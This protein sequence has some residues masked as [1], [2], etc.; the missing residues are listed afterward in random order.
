MAASKWT[1]YLGDQNN[2]RVVVI[3]AVALVQE[4]M[5]RHQLSDVAGAGLGEAAVG[6][7]M[8]AS[9]QKDGN[10]LNLSIR[11]DGLLK[12]VVVDA[13]PE[14]H[15]RGYVLE[16]NKEPN[17]ENVGPWGRGILS[18]LY[19]KYEESDQPYIGTV[20][21]LT[22]HLAQDLTHF[23]LQSAQLPSIV[24]LDVQVQSGRVS[25]AD[26]FLIQ[27]LGN[28]S[29]DERRIV[30]S[31]ADRIQQMTEAIGPS[32]NALEVLGEAM[33]SLKFSLVEDSQLRFECSCSYERVE[34]ALILTGADELQSMIDKGEPVKAHCEFCNTEYEFLVEHIKILKKL[35]YD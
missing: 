27:T 33:P 25:K 2:L 23:W 26:G 28:A 34:R 35:S 13:Y 21:L 6:I 7:L 22:G 30:Y 11:G 3:E 29:D 16:N 8:M 1:K 5:D 19:T 9:A 18:V 31:L 15:V 24:G 20:P 12:Q 10:R 14:G 4:L 17:I 32:K